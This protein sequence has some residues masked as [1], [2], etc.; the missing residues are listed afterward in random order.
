MTSPFVARIERALAKGD[1]QGAIGQAERALSQGVRHPLVLRM[2]A[3]GRTEAG[4]FADAGALLNQALAFDRAD[5]D[6]LCALGVLL[7][8]EGRADEAS[9]VFTQ[10]LKLAPTHYRGWLGLAQAL[11]AVE[12]D[13][14]ALRAYARAASLTTGDPQPQAGMAE[15]HLRAGRAEAAA[16]AAART[17]AIAPANSVAT[18]VNARIALR[19]KDAE[20]ARFLAETLIIRSKTLPPFER[21]TVLKTLADAY[22]QLGRI[23]EAIG[24]Y[25]RMNQAMVDAH[26]PRF[27]PGGAVENHLAFMARLREGYAKT[28]DRWRAAPAEIALSPVARHVFVMGYPRSGNTLAA[29]VLGSLPNAH[30]LEERPTLL[31]T[32]LEFFRGADGISRMAALDVEDAER[33]RGL[34]WDRVRSEGVSLDS[35]T[36][37]DMAPLNSI[38]LPMIRKL[39]PSAAIVLCT[40]DPRDVVLS[41]WRQS[42]I[43][44]ASTY[45]M[46]DLAG[47]ARHLDAAMRLTAECLS[48]IGE[49]GV[50]C[51]NY[52]AFIGDF[53]AGARRL[54]QAV[55]LPWSDAALNFAEG[56]Q[57]RR[58]RT[59]S[60]AQVRGGLFDGRAQWRRYEAYLQSVMP[61]LNP[62]I[63]AE[64]SG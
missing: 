14:A 3:E 49:Q 16:E 46:T 50:Q 15:L 5:P 45:Q 29:A 59:A 23:P 28:P 6:S 42:F 47:A 7:T 20:T 30:V 44:N 54:L 9:G 35:A 25:E 18:L 51:L 40:R 64:A 57:N 41:C 32:E 33:L 60:A 48:M 34:Y 19:R 63:Q 4:R 62:W 10:V 37:I 53:E 11:E 61:I 2:A 12:N 17:L 39:F 22:D 8:R 1:R 13:D 38:K 43:A 52:E 55:G 36:V 31:D 27:G 26:K 24:A 56:A 21:Q 58:M